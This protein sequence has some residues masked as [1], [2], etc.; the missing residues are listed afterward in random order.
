MLLIRQFK[1][2]FFIINLDNFLIIKYILRKFNL[3]LYIFFIQVINIL[4]LKNHI[5]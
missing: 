4:H 1:N 2:N 3:F 5:I